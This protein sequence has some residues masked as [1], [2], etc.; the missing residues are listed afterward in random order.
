MLLSHHNSAVDLIGSC[1]RPRITDSF[2][3]PQPLTMKEVVGLD[4]EAGIEVTG[5]EKNKFVYDSFMR[6]NLLFSI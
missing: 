4:K 3:S 6:T 1:L 5:G 2:L